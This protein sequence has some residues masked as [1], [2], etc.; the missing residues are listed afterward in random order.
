MECYS[1]E[2]CRQVSNCSSTPS[3][4]CEDHE[5]QL[6]LLDIFFQSKLYDQWCKGI[7]CC[8]VVACLEPPTPFPPAPPPVLFTTPPPFIS[9]NT[10]DD[11]QQQQ[12]DDIWIMVSVFGVI[13]LGIAG[14]IVYRY[15]RFTTN[16]SE[17]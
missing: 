3:N 15:R 12:N 8:E 6:N 7:T 14:T 16:Q 13:F 4:S 2:K 17:Q 9:S 1:P 10:N 11:F 5:H